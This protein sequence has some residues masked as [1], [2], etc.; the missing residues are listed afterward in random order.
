MQQASKQSAPSDAVVIG[1]DGITLSEFA[2][3]WLA[4]QK[5]RLRPNSY[6]IYDSYLRHH[7]RPRLGDR[8]LSTITV[9]DVAAV[10]SEMEQGVRLRDRG[11]KFERIIGHPFATP[12]IFG[13][14]TV[15]SRIFSRACRRGLVTSNPVSQ[16]EREELP[17]TKRREFPTL[18]REAIGKLLAKTPDR[19]RAVVALSVLTGLRQSETLGLRWQDIDG[20][21]GI[22]RVRF[23]LDRRG[24]LVEPKT[25]AS[26]RDVPIPPSLVRMLEV[27]RRDARE[28]GYGRPTDF[29]FASKTG[30][31]ISRRNLMR[32][33][34]RTAIDR[35]DLPKL[36][37]HDLRHVAAS[38]LIAE[39]ASVPYLARILGHSSPTITLAVYA[40]EFAR[41]EHAERTRERMEAAFGELL[42]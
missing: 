7:I 16:L 10:I 4:Q 14:L 33:G 39:G 8:V 36:S 20:A 42:R 38:A 27:R 19:F 37:W 30:G 11:G 34:L 24:Q 21:G 32:R 6:R 25:V 17:K 22:L 40:H 28:R 41:A 1:S 15:L 2:D 9:D 3:E 26:K 23:Q 13:V 29:V 35:S 5:G 12:T 18:D 31:P